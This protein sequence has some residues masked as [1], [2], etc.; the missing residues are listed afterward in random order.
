MVGGQGAVSSPHDLIN[1][2][3][4]WGAQIRAAPARLRIVRRIEDMQRLEIGATL[5]GRKCNSGDL[6]SNSDDHSNDPHPDTL[7]VEANKFWEMTPMSYQQ[8]SK[9]CHLVRTMFIDSQCVTLKVLEMPSLLHFCNPYRT[10]I[11]ESEK[12]LIAQYKW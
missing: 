9:W 1:E 2:L 5:R 7:R 3:C 8:E 4:G 12:L 10:S 11:T 6:I